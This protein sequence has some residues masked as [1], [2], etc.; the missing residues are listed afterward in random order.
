VVK[1]K[2]EAQRE[3]WLSKVFKSQSEADKSYYKLLSYLAHRRRK[4][5]DED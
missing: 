5:K 1:E 2:K 4:E 3:R